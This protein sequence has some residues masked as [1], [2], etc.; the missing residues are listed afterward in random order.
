MAWWS[1]F[2]LING[3]AD[4]VEI[5]LFS[6]AIYFFSCWCA[7]DRR[8]PL[9]VYFYACCAGGIFAHITNL[10][11]IIAFLQ[12]GWPVLIIIFIVVHQH[13]LQKNYIAGKVVIPAQSIA[14]KSW[15]SLIL[16]AGIRAASQKKHLIFVIQRN[17]IL[18]DFIDG[19][20]IF[21]SPV[22]KELLDMIV[23]SPHAQGDRL[24]LIN[25]YGTLQAINGTWRINLSEESWIESSI[26]V[27]GRTDAIICAIDQ[28]TRLLTL[29]AQGTCVEQLAPDK[30][31][32]ILMQYIRKYSDGRS[33]ERND[34][35]NISLS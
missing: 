1:Q 26:I 31:E 16:R 28:Q 32:T 33:H 34:K 20:L 22:S 13:T 10:S 18:D 35:K 17:D 9:L 14:Q 24:V 8:T 21:N 2:F 11:T 3:W 29:I 7:R 4:I 27:T 5:F 25:Q 6:S 19:H 23:E 12:V 30:A 15:I